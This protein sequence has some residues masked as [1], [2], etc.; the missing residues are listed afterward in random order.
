M[1]RLLSSV[2]VS[3]SVAL[4]FVALT[5]HAALTFNANSITS[6]GVFNLT[7]NGVSTIDI[8]NNLLDIQTA[9]NGP[10]TFGTGLV[11]IPGVI[12][13]GTASG[14]G[15]QVIN[16][17]TTR[18]NISSLG[19]SGNP[20]LSVSASGSVAT[21]TC[22]GGGSS[23]TINGITT[24]TFTFAA[25]GN[26]SVATSA[27]STITYAFVNPGFVTA[28][29]SVTWSAAQTDNATTTFGGNMLISNVTSSVLKTNASG[30]IGAVIIGSGLSFSGSTLSATGGGGSS[31][32]IDGLTTSTY[33]I[34]A[35]SNIT[36]TTSSPGTITIAASGGGGGSA[37]STFFIT[38]TTA[39][40][41]SDGNGNP[42][43]EDESFADLD[44][45]FIPMDGS[46]AFDNTEIGVPTPISGTVSN[47]VVSLAGGALSNG[48][49]LVVYLNDNGENTSLT[50]ILSHSTGNTCEDGTHKVP[51]AAG[52]LLDFELEPSGNPSAFNPVSVQIAA[53]F[54]Y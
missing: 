22:G 23:I 54:Q 10:V 4:F 24:S 51:V 17:T 7:G 33:T 40:Y 52:D 15:I 45:F 11:A 25:G 9:N 26:L 41:T 39:D 43:D 50:C 3:L 1:R 6:D 14:T 36:I 19:S 13:F 35:G 37:S 47:L 8:G 49:S 44:S 29:S 46:G 34:A 5:A 42:A 16:A 20:C 27:P 32:T 30:T 28:A 48:S 12:S 18:L 2:I 53:E 31:I 21:S 38:G